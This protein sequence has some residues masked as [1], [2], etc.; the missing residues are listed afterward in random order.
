MMLVLPGKV[1]RTE[2]PILELAVV[3]EVEELPGT[4]PPNLPSQSGLALT[5]EEG[6][7]EGWTSSSSSSCSA[8][9]AT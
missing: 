1:P 4:A 9:L 3:V 6:V 7:E 5:L 2:T 8:S